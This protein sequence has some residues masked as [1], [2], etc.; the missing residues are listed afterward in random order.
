MNL[1][2]NKWKGSPQWQNEQD[3][4]NLCQEYYYQTRIWCH[5]WGVSPSKPYFEDNDIICIYKYVIIYIYILIM[6]QYHKGS[7]RGSKLLPAKLQKKNNLR[8]YWTL[9]TGAISNIERIGYHIVSGR[10]AI[11]AK[12]ESRLFWEDSPTQLPCW[13][14]LGWSRDN[15]PK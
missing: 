3:L 8:S 9:E 7:R 5:F 11:I 13:G 15:L 2:R 1:R 6:W 14:G 12:P 10:I 4:V